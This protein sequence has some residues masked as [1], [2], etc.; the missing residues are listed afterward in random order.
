MW[1][2]GIIV[3]ALMGG[4]FPYKE[5]EP[6]ALAEEAR[7]TRLYFP[8]KPWNGISEAGTLF[9]SLCLRAIVPETDPEV[10]L[11]PNTLF[12]DYSESI[13]KSD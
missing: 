12:R 6:R 11:Q 9:A 7:T 1:S 13:P 3:F 8:E 5:V 4:R 10:S 2:V